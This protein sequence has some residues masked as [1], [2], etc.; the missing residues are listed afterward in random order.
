M[1]VHQREA[2]LLNHSPHG[3]TQRRG[4][5]TI[6]GFNRNGLFMGQGKEFIEVLFSLAAAAD[7]AKRE[8]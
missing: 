3:D 2:P 1:P 4:G 6:A 5:R 8:L 7:R